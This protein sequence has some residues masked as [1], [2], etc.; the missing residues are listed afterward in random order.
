MHIILLVHTEF[1]FKVLNAQNQQVFFA[2][3]KSD[4]FAKMCCKNMRRFEMA[5][6]GKF[7]TVSLDYCNVA[8][9]FFNVAYN[10]FHLR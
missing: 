2:A 7:W 8:Y 6:T 1:Y 4:C 10:F 5:V 9:H 3:E